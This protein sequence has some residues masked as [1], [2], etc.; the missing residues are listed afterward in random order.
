MPPRPV[1]WTDFEGLYALRAH[2]YE[3]IARDPGYGMVSNPTKPTP[4]EFASWFGE[5][6]RAVLEGRR[7]CSVAEEAG[8]IVGMCSVV[9]EG[10]AVETRHVGVLGL[11]VLPEFR[12][13]GLGEALLAHALEACRGRFEAVDLSVI[14]ANERAARLY[15]KLGFRIYGRRP[16]AFQRGG[17]YHDFILMLKPIDPLP[18]PSPTA[19]PPVRPPRTS[20]GR[21]RDAVKARRTGRSDRSR[22]DAKRPRSR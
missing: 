21:A 16:K 14:P 17:T 7:V 3:E 20:R 8:R 12:G 15:R 10:T 2:R 1:R 19:E 5:M 11:E 13:R 6:H 18:S 4:G 22:T 9:A